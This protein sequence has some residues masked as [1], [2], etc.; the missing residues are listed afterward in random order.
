MK[1]PITAIL[2]LAMT[3]PLMAGEA[4]PPR[5]KNPRTV[6]FTQ[7]FRQYDTDLDELLSEEEFQGTVGAGDVPV[8]TKYRFLFLADFPKV[9]VGQA[10]AGAVI[11]GGITVE[12]YIRYAG[13]LRVPNP[14]RAIRFELADEDEDGFLDFS[15]YAL[16][17]NALA[18]KPGTL[19]K[20]FDKLDKNDD[21]QISPA[22][23]KVPAMDT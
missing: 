19:A 15:E 20:S 6:V 4:P 16:T 14:N 9:E 3:A 12:K 18:A 17:R 22:E 2:L 1:T 13:G 21:E 23:F 5:K 8:L 10:A 7:Y 11:E